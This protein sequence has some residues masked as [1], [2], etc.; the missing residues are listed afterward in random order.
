M[1]R[2]TN[3]TTSPR[4]PA[5]SSG[6]SRA[7]KPA[8]APK[9][10]VDEPDRPSALV[11]AWMGLAH[12]T[13]GVFRAFGPET[14][15]K[16]Q[17]RDGFP[18]LLV[19]L[20]IAGAVVEW[21]LIGTDVGT[22]ISAYTVGAL[23]GREAFVLPVLLLLLAGWLFRHPSSVHDN[24]RIGIGFGLF[25]LAV[26]G[27]CHVLGSRPQPRSGLPALSEAGGLFGWMVGEPL[28]FLTPVG[29]SIVLGLIA[30]L[31]VLI[32]TKTPPNRIGQRLGDLYAW[33][34][35]AERAERPA[36]A[37]GAAVSFEKDDEKDDA[38]PWWRRNKSGREEDVDGHLGSD[39]LTALLEASPAGGFEQAVAAP[40]VP[41]PPSEAPTEV[42]DPS[43]VAGARRA[44]RGADLGIREDAEEVHDDGLLPGLSGLGGD[45][46]GRPPATPYRLPS[47]DAL[48]AGTPHK[49]RSEANDQV[50]RAIT[51]VF[52]QFSVDARVTGFSRGPTVTQYEIELGPGVKVE[53]IT[54]LTNNIAYAVASNEVRI[55]APIPGKSAIGVEIP[56]TDREIVT[57]GDVLRSPAASAQ[58][59][60]MTIG[61]GKDVGGGYVIANLAK[62]P[63]LLVA[64]ST[65]SGK[66]SFVNSMITSLLMRA[67]PSDVRMVLIDPKRVE[68]TSY[69]GVPH[70]I[71]PII[72]NPKKAAEALQWVVKEMDMR[73]DDLAS[74]GFRHIDDFNRAVVAGEID[75]P[76]GSERV[77]KP[78]PYL[79][80]VVDE[81]ADLMMVAPRD[82]EDSIVRI[83]QLARASGI[84][85]VLATQR[86]SVDVV[87]GLIKANVPSR[88]AF[89]VTSVT[90]SRVILDQPGA[91][92]LIGQGDG[93][94]LP[95]GA[96][97]AVRVQGAWVAE[98]EIEKVVAHVKKQAQPDYRSD[99]AAVA[100]K[101][102]IDADIGDDLDLLLAA[103][104][105][106]ISTQFGSTS[107]L[108]RKLRVGFAKAGRLMD[109]LESRE[110]VGPSEGSKARDVLVTPDQLP[111]VL[112]RLRGEE[113]P[114]ASADAVDAQF[115]GYE[116]VDGDSGDEDAWGLTGRD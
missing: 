71:T 34:F 16:D 82:V 42:I 49:A 83:T 56:N 91:D 84:H 10:Y 51:G 12:A 73:Y 88:L 74:F 112:A 48:A 47:V 116:V 115:D 105:Q 36:P 67:K 80:V 19:L 60:P 1:A 113:P 15:E 87:T 17:R 24:G 104:E 59:H 89:A 86:P 111:G 21:F 70:L 58:T 41:P 43:V 39:D 114:S 99:V 103:A 31:S 33:M 55:L 69:A 57:L 11:R 96:S 6:S 9:R 32:L 90:D 45:H 72:T 79:L 20:A 23:V 26:A 22:T 3:P 101:K 94:F 102:E 8:P 28:T 81:L 53:R 108:Q 7:K 52:S 18:F 46:D 63:H 65:G 78:Y 54:A 68:L 77:L 37:D 29:A 97:K 2:S 38:L 106:I 44:A 100:E 93:L 61:V 35:G 13:G 5:K 76:A 25:V 98:S 27:F 50:V 85:L 4:T 62:M 30:V 14:L 110:I 109:L 40:P 95:M 75:L 66:S 92:R 64:G 107:M